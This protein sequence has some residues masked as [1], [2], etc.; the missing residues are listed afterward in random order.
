MERKKQYRLN[1]ST[2][3]AVPQV[4][5]TTVTHLDR[6]DGNYVRMLF[7][8]FSSAFINIVPTRLHSKLVNL[9]LN[10]SL[11]AWILDFLSNR[12]QVVRVGKH[13]SS[14][15]T[16]ITGSPQGCV[17]SP[18]ALHPVYTGPCGHEQLQLHRGVRGWHGSGRLHQEQQWA[19]LHGG[20]WEPDTVVPGQ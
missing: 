12:S 17:L 19:D 10:T 16:L 5:H 20:N 13:T 8:D 7:I 11:C 4:L 1:R 14:P 2:D 9:G 6:R 18:P 3:D 15:R